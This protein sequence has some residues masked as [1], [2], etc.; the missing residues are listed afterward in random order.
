[1][2][3]Y[4]RNIN[5]LAVAMKKCPMRGFFVLRVRWP[6]VA[7]PRATIAPPAARLAL[8]FLNSAVMHSNPHPPS[9]AMS[10]SAKR[11]AVIGGGPAGLMA[12]EGLAA[13]GA[14]VDV[15]DA[16]PSVGRKFLMAGRGG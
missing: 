11:V 12:A 16:M 14:Q 8:A 2:S 7:P 3:Q 1:M 4:R 13:R 6:G 9:G 5:G 10:P 15:Y